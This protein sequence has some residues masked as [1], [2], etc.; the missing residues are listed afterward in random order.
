MRVRRLVV[1][2][3]MDVEECS[4]CGRY[5]HPERPH[6]LLVFLACFNINICPVCLGCLREELEFLNNKSEKVK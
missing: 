3:L 2:D 5:C 1:D 4:V 6:S